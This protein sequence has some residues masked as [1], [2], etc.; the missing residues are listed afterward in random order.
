MPAT[1]AS[2]SVEGDAAKSEVGGGKPS[3]EAAKSK[4]ESA[5]PIGTTEKPKAKLGV[6]YS[7]WD[8][9]ELSEDE[10]HP[11]DWTRG[12]KPPFSKE[13]DRP[14]ADDDEDDCECHDTDCCA[15]ECCFN[16]EVRKVLT[17]AREMSDIT[18]RGKLPLSTPTTPA[19]T[20][21]NLMSCLCD[22]CSGLRLEALTKLLSKKEVILTKGHSRHS[23]T[24]IHKHILK[25]YSS[26]VSL[27]LR[28]HGLSGSGSRNNKLV[29]LEAVQYTK[30]EAIRRKKDSWFD[31]YAGHNPKGES[32]GRRCACR[33]CMLAEMCVDLS[34]FI[35]GKSRVYQV[36]FFEF[37]LKQITER[38][39]QLAESQ[40]ESK[41]GD[42]V[43]RTKGIDYSKWEK[44]S[45]D[46][47]DS[48][49]DEESGGAAFSSPAT[50]GM[51]DSFM[52]FM[53][54]AAPSF[55]GEMYDP[56]SVSGTPP[57]T[58][59]VMKEHLAMNGRDV[60]SKKGGKKKGKKE[61]D[62]KEKD[63]QK[64][65]KEKEK[66][67]EKEKEKEKAKEK[68]KEKEKLKEKEKDKAKE[69]EKTKEKEQVKAWTPKQCKACL[70]VESKPKE[71]LLCSN[72][73][74]VHYCSAQC[75]RKDWKEHKPSCSL[76]AKQKE[77]SKQ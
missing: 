29:Q 4:T 2:S 74:S 38:Q 23:I 49:E 30:R 26:M 28:A 40:N 53:S 9:L 68:E 22:I 76:I 39:K 3:A 57:F 44:M 70:K 56:F 25:R 34:N 6:D 48:S 1:G 45:L 27:Y 37:A 52:A 16:R 24:I 42:S 32:H 41:S 33:A 47:D 77:A 62:A 5:V 8:K 13:S 15:Y 11:A 60:P 46:S 35:E 31:M 59:E 63:R 73:C 21:K 67:K 43:V 14:L 10:D 20:C 55:N 19:R 64:P 54:G 65:E 51:L 17:D 72:C 69:K 61:D 12:V 18:L 36:Q 58:M 75:Q 66:A 7:K 71:W 50:Y